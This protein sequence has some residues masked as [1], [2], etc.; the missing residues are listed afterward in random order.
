MYQICEIHVKTM[1]E[2][3]SAIV[4]GFLWTR[5]VLVSRKVEIINK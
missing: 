5:I 4:I 1:E 2:M 3:Y